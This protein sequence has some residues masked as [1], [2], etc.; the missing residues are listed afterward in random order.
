MEFGELINSLENK[1]MLEPV[2]KREPAVANLRFG[3]VLEQAFGEH[4]SFFM[5]LAVAAYP[6]NLLE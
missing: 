4:C 6:R 2:P 3:L 1:I 5:S